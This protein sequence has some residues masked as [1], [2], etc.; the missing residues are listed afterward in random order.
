M[1]DL[2]GGGGTGVREALAA[3]RRDYEVAGDL[4]LEKEP[5]GRDSN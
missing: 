4:L 1:M 5:N 2:R 3:G